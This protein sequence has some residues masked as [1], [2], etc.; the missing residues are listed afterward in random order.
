MQYA[1]FLHG[2]AN[3]ARRSGAVALL[4]TLA[5]AVAPTQAQDAKAGAVTIS[6][7]WARATPAPVRTSAAYLTLDNKG[8][9]DRLLSA[10]ADVAKET[11]LHSMITEAGVMKMREVKGIDVAANGK[12]ELKPGGFHI[13]LVGLADGLKEGTKFPLKLKFEKAGEVTVQVTAEKPDA[14]GHGEHKH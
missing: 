9:A 5:L 3:T 4:V 7:A 1:S 12:T 2:T 6:H 8:G 14:H 10:S 13:M 11:Q